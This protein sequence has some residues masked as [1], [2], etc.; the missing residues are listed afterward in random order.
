MT[1]KIVRAFVTLVV[2]AT[3]IANPRSVSAEYLEIISPAD[4]YQD[5]QFQIDIRVSAQAETVYQVKARI[6][7]AKNLLTKGQTFDEGN[8]V[9]LSDSVGWDKFPNI[10]TDQNGVWQ[11]NLKVKTSSTTSLGT[12]LLLVRLHN[13][14]KNSN[15]D[16]PTYTINVSQSLPPPPPAPKSAGKPILSEFM[17]QPA[18]KTEWV[19]L[20]NLGTA[21][22]DISGW[23]IDD[24]DG[25]AA[26]A[27]IP[28]NTLVAS[29][30][31]FVLNFAS[32]K[33]NDLSDSVRLLKP[34]GSV[35]ETF[36]YPKSIKGQSWAKDKNGNWL[37][38]SKPTPGAEN[39][40][41]TPVTAP[42]VA[43]PTTQTTS[44]NSGPNEAGV[45]GTNTSP[46]TL[47]VQPTLDQSDKIATVSASFAKKPT[48]N[49]LG[50]AFLASGAVLLVGAVLIIFK[51]F[52]WKVLVKKEKAAL[53]RS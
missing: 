42:K 19:E 35:V 29:G 38:T 33:L 28:E 18:D 24:E 7:Q 25:K 53:P 49:L 23:K 17:P 13:S 14:T 21:S 31:Y 47:S 45:L 16:S 41:D 52:F 44:A 5:T 1:G 20:Q 43:A 51:K 6:G 22:A 32:F 50:F 8:G 27:T 4:V 36:T 46:T 9:W 30:G 12:N 40:F 11:G 37:L 34:D 39:K 26:P 15:Y 3:I 48:D 2:L 10:Q